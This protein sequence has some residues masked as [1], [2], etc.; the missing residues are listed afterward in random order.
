[1]KAELNHLGIIMDG[2]GR[3][4]ARRG[5]PRSLGHKAGIAAAKRIVESAHR[6]G[7]AYLTLYAFS[8]DNWSRDRR[9]VDAIFRLVDGYLT[10]ELRTLAAHGVRVQVIGRRDR[11][12]DRT[13]RVIER[14]EKV[15]QAGE[16]M[17]LRLAIDYSSRD[18]LVAAA[19]ALVRMQPP[20]SVIDREL[21]FERLNGAINSSRVPDIDLV[22]RTSGEQRLSDFCLWECAYAELFFTP[23]L[24]PDFDDVAL[25]E[26]LAAFGNRQ[27]RFGS[28]A[29]T[30]QAIGVAS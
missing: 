11:L 6:R 16:A 8:A 21:F 25:A 30:G 3:W 15:T 28:A 23:V 19:A 10:D 29:A 13:R 7:I 22:I 2:N 17:L 9:E 24:W 4:A 18:A 1:M 5:L 20:E 14:A 27:R 12:P 26:A